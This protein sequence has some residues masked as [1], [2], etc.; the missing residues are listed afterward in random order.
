MEPQQQHSPQERAEMRETLM[1]LID[2]DQIAELLAPRVLEILRAKAATA[3]SQHPSQQKTT[4]ANPMS[5]KN[6]KHSSGSP[7]PALRVIH[8][9]TSTLSASEADKP[10]S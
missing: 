6:F 3:K 5:R 7:R 2:L 10:Q 8:G 9:G 4:S 1:A